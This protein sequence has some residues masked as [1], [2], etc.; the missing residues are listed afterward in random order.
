[1]ISMSVVVTMTVATRKGVLALSQ[2]GRA[3]SAYAAES[4][5][6]S[7]WL[8]AERIGALF[9]AGEGAP[10]ALELVHR[11]SRERGGSVV[12]SFVLVDFVDGNGVVDDGWLDGLLLDYGLDVLVNM[13]VDVLACDN[14]VG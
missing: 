8:A 10:L 11:H 12:L 14:R 9:A 2:R 5:A 7:A 1:M 4:S 13:V 6:H 3:L